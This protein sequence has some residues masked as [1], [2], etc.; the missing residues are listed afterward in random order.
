MRQNGE[1][2]LMDRCMFVALAF[3]FFAALG[4]LLVLLL[5]KLGVL[6]NDDFMT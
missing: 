5:G 3:V 4:F 1:F 2:T 6:P